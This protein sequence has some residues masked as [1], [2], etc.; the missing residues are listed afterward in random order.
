MGRLRSKNF[1]CIWDLDGMRD[2][3]LWDLMVEDHFS[4]L[5]TRG[6]HW[7][8][9]SKN[10][11][12]KNCVCKCSTNSHTLSDCSVKIFFKKKTIDWGKDVWE[13]SKIALFSELETHC[14]Y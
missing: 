4:L 1:I 7:T 12:V 14:V 11:A 10:S 3:D 9:N 13:L 2:P 8:K 6:A 5:T